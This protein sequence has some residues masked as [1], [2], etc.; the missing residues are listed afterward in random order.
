M[1]KGVALKCVRWVISATA[2]VLCAVAV[3]PLMAAEEAGPPLKIA[4]D[5][6]T[7]AVAAGEKPLLEYRFAGVPFKPCVR[8]FHTPAGVNVLRDSPHDHVHHHALMFAVA[9]DGVGFWTEAPKK[10]G[11]QVHRSVSGSTGSASGGVSTATVTGQLDW[12]TP[13]KKP[14][15]AEKRTIVVYHGKDLPASLLTW[16]TVLQPAE[17]KDSVA[18]TGAHYYGLGLRFVQSMDGVGRFLH[19]S[20]EEGKVIRGTERLTRDKWCAYTA[21]AEGK[22]VTIAVFDHPDNARHPAHMFTMT[23]HFSYLAA[24]LHLWKEPMKLTAKTP[25]DLRYGVALWDGAQ[26]AKEIEK[27][28]DRWVKLASGK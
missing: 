16:R 7:V 5:K 17:G 6:T 19:S 25:L 4:K 12:I 23:R 3:G 13:D 11:S 24:T 8:R 9:A 18:L 20:G 1:K 21:P 26:E 28:Y 27:L 15:L 22:Q 10:S 2:A 14:V